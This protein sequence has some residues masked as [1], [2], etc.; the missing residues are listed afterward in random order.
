MIELKG[1]RAGYGGREILHGVDISFQPG[2][3]TILCGPNGCGKSTL[4]R[5]ALGLIPRMGGEVLYDG[6]ELSGLS[7]REVA[8]RAA[9][10]PQERGAPSITVRRLALHGRFPYLDIPRRYTAADLAAAERA[11]KLADALDIA[12]APLP[13]LSGG[14]RQRAFLAMALAQETP[15]LLM[16]EPTAFLDA[17]HQLRVMDAAQRLAREGRAVVMVLHD[18]RLAL[19]CAD[20]LAV[21]A[22]GALTACGSP[23]EV[24]SSGAIDAAFGVALGRVHTDNGWQYYYE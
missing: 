11:L 23:E 10:M 3:I 12:D 1:L 18:L 17:G 13:E 4:L 6:V 5:A 20:T 2:R 16:D 15:A 24:Y 14:Q 7:R 8:R 22:D 9:Y 19:R 21:L